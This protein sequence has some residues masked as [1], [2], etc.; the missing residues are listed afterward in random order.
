MCAPAVLKSLLCWFEVSH[1]EKCVASRHVCSPWS[2]RTEVADRVR[3]G[4]RG[5]AAAVMADVDPETLLEWLSMG[6]GEERDLQLIALEQ[7]CCCSCR[8]M[9]T[10]ASRGESAAARREGCAG[11]GE[12]WLGQRGAGIEQKLKHMHSD[13]E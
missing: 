8:T 13:R 6:Q 3:Q 4:P 7:L 1:D 2:V 11:A 9:W 10:A 12:R 5:A